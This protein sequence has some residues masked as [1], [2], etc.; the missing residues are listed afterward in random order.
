M[1]QIRFH[2]TTHNWKILYNHS[3]FLKF[4]LTQW[5]CTFLLLYIFIF[6]LFWFNSIIM[7]CCCVSMS[8]FIFLQYNNI[9]N[10][11]IFFMTIQL[12]IIFWF[13]IVSYWTL[14]FYVEISWTEFY[15]CEFESE[16]RSKV[17]NSCHSRWNEFIRSFWEYPSLFGESK[18]ILWFFNV[19]RKISI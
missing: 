2:S 18:R 1:L 17:K 16:K 11:R 4:N 13:Y 14:S 3:I 7:F 15:Y 19:F 12:S 6:V 10:N 8:I 5:K 9:I